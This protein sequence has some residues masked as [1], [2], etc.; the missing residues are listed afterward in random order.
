MMKSFHITFHFYGGKKVVIK[1]ATNH[2]GTNRRIAHVRHILYQLCVKMGFAYKRFIVVNVDQGYNKM[3]ADVNVF[4][5]L[6]AKL[7]IF[8]VLPEV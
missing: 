7:C 3:A 8:L 1:I 4:L 2:T 5:D 6:S